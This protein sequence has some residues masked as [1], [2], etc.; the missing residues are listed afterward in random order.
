MQLYAII[1]NYIVL[2]FCQIFACDILGGFFQSAETQTHVIFNETQ[3]YE[4]FSIKL[5]GVLGIVYI[6]IFFC[7]VPPSE[8]P[9][10]NT[11]F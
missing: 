3:I 6:S 2:H 4:Y 7:L 11:T 9:V 5:L 8:L 10:G 1:C